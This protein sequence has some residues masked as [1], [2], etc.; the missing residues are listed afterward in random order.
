MLPIIDGNAQGESLGCCE[1][2]GPLSMVAFFL[3]CQPPASEAYGQQWS[4]KTI[5]AYM[6]DEL[7]PD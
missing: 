7:V 5:R 3:L 6:V 2:I 1:Y 4:T